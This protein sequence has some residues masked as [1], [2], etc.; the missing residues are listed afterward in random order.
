MGSYTKIKHTEE[1]ATSLWFVV[2][3]EL[4]R[5]AIVCE[6]MYEWS[7]DWLCSILQGKSYP[8]PPKV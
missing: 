3:N 2:V 1:S 5:Q 8:C 4:G 6:K 7:A